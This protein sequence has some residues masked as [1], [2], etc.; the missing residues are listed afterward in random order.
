MF[1]ISKFHRHTDTQPVKCP[2]RSH[3]SCTDH[4]QWYLH[5]H[6]KSYFD[7]GHFHRARAQCTVGCTRDLGRSGD[8]QQGGG[9]FLIWDGRDRGPLW[10]TYLELTCAELSFVWIKVFTA[11]VPFSDKP[12]RA[13]MLAIVGGKR[14]PRPIHPTL[15]DRLWGLTRRCWDQE[16]RRRPQVLQIL[17]GL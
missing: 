2:R 1:T 14:P 9:R 13:A 15:T 3:R 11:A 8:M 6:T 7:T 5:G 4:K 16:P 12:P 10:I 17:C